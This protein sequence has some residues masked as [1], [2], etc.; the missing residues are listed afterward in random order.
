MTLLIN[1]QLC[2]RISSLQAWPGHGTATASRFV[3][4][5]R[6]RLSA[7]SR[8]SRGPPSCSSPSMM[9]V[10]LTATRRLAGSLEYSRRAGVAPG[11]RMLRRRP[12]ARVD[13][14]DDL[15]VRVHLV[16][17]MRRGVPRRSVPELRRGRAASA[18]SAGGSPQRQPGFHTTPGEHRI[19]PDIASTDAK[20]HRA[21]SC[22]FFAASQC[23]SASRH[24]RR[25]GR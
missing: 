23:R 17:A 7:A 8:S 2:L 4:P 20:I 24:L 16:R 13:G 19:T 12:A 22:V 11:L 1:P 15:H 21:G 6:V 25:M 18:R 3:R 9:N 10:R 14:R 5:R